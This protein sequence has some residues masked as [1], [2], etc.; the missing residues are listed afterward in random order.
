MTRT[1]PPWREGG[2]ALRIGWD[3]E[4]GEYIIRANGGHIIGATSCLEELG[5]LI[6]FESDWGY[7]AVEL[8][9]QGCSTCRGSH[10]LKSAP[11]ISSR[12]RPSR[13]TSRGS[14]LTLEDLGL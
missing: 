11:T 6:K 9:L 2:P 5:E 7:G 13:S 8:K 14:A 4:A 3:P 10:G 12:A 1:S